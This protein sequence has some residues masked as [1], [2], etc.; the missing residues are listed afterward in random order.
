MAPSC[1]T[2]APLRTAVPE[3]VLGPLLRHVGSSDA[4]VWVETDTPCEV[5]VRAGGASGR[6]RSFRVGAHHYAL[7]HAT[8][9]TPGVSH[10]YEVRLDGEVVWPEPGSR[11]PASV[12]RVPGEGELVKLVFG[13]CRISAPHE[14]PYSSSSEEDERGLGVDALYAMAMRLRERPAEEL[15]HALV[16]LGDQIYAHKPPYD[17]LDFIRSRRDTSRPPGEEVADFEEYAR[18]YRD[19]W[20]DPAIRWLL[21]TV[22]SSMIFDDH[23]VSDDWNIS[24]AWLEETRAKPWW[25]DQI[26]GANASYWIYQHL[27]NL[28]PEELAASELF[29]KVRRAQDAWPLLREFAYHAHRTSEGTRWSSCRDFGNVRLIVMD[30]RGGRVLEE[31]HRSMIDAREWSWI[32][33]KATGN[34]DHLL[35]ATSLPVLL[36]PGMH[37]LQAWNEAVCAGA[38]GE[39]AKGL[40]EWVRRSQDLDQWASFQDSFAALTG[41]IQCIAGGKK[42]D[43]PS[44]ITILSGDVHHGYLAEASFDGTDAESR[45][46][47]AVCSP[48]RNALPGEKSHL[49]N[50]AWTK[51]AALAGRL[52][53]RLA[54]VEPP[55]LTWR[56]THEAPWFENHVATLQLDGRSASITFEEAVTDDSGEPGLRRIYASRLT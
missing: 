20:G 50:V 6:S 21:S 16:L 17:T 32:E 29:E 8:G 48:L 56:L 24:E 38:W 42:G 27:G 14:E 45:I 35:F 31:G 9:L 36:G 43:P 12:V 7:V 53:S 44:S 23:E 28:S 2:R 11:F 37:D 47:Q 26:V 55:N 49:Q 51:P 22:P 41:L 19:S 5:E 46:Y 54:G 13:S 1:H 25:N 40:G 34:F 39:R 4:T 3:L 33:D 15:P 30:S 10:E 52:L 18:L